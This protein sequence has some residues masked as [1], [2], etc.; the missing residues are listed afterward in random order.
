HE[1]STRASATPRKLRQ[2][3]PNFMRAV[4]Y[5]SSAYRRDKLLHFALHFCGIGHGGKHRFAEQLP[6]ALAQ[7]VDGYGHGGRRH[8]QSRGCLRVITGTAFLT[9]EHAQSIEK[10]LLAV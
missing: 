1:T 6:V 5:I 9:E 8:A 10:F 2:C 3:Q 7:P 4:Y